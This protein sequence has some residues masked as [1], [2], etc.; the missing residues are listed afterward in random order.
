M[1][2]SKREAILSFSWVVKNLGNREKP[3]HHHL[4]KG[5]AD[6]SVRYSFSMEI[7]DFV[8]TFVSLLAICFTDRMTDDWTGDVQTVPFSL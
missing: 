4:P 1:V 3:S 8:R 6:R 2:G 5:D 7:L